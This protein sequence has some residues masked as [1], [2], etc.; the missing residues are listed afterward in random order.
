[1][2]LWHTVAEQYNENKHTAGIKN[3]IKLLGD[4]IVKLL[5]TNLLFVTKDDDNNIR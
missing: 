5:L 2:E 4:K 3:Y 1:M